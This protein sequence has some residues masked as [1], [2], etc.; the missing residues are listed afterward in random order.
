MDNKL[1]KTNKEVQL[2]QHQEFIQDILDGLF[3]PELPIPAPNT[4]IDYSKMFD[5]MDR[6]CAW[7]YISLNGYFFNEYWLDPSINKKYKK[8][9][10]K[11]ILN[12]ANLI[13]QVDEYYQ[14]I[15]EIL[16]Q[17]IAKGAMTKN[18]DGTFA[19]YILC[20]RKGWEDVSKQEIELSAKTIDW[21]WDQSRIEPETPEDFDVLNE[22]EE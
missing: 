2:E 19:K 3:R 11:Q 20:R 15:M 18:F 9:K 8:F 12:A 22:T 5:Q 14:W 17:K 7:A 6:I 13:P 16:T 4:V 1:V 10:Q 21:R